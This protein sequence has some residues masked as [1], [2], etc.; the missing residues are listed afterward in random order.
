MVGLVTELDKMVPFRC[1]GR[2]CDAHLEVGT[3][4]LAFNEVSGSLLSMSCS[5]GERGLTSVDA[6]DWHGKD[7]S[8]Y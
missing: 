5:K 7:E 8:E 1:V 3:A 2:G 6:L 4:S